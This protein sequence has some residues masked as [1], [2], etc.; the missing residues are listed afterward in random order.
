MTEGRETSRGALVG[1]PGA[2]DE[3]TQ[4]QRVD[5][6]ES[7]CVRGPDRGSSSSGKRPTIESGQKCQECPGSGVGCGES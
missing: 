3:G 4:Q 1:C 5:K 7:S 2:S 6:K